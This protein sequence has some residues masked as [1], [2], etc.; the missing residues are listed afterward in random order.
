[1]SSIYI[2][3]PY[4]KQKCSYCSFYY[5]ISQKDKKEMINSLKKEIELRKQYLNNNTIETIYFGGGTPSILTESEISLLINTITE[6]YTVINN[7]EISLECNPDDLTKKKVQNLKKSGINRLSIGI[8]SFNDED[9][10]FMNR[11]HNS[12]QAIESVQ[13]AK[14]IGFNN[15]SIDLMYSLPQ[16]SLEKWKKNLDIAFSLE[17]QHISAYSLTIEEKTKL[18]SLLKKGE[19]SE[20]DDIASSEHFDLLMMEA[21]KNKFIQYEISNFGLNGF[22]S[23]HN[24][25]YWQ[26]GHYLGIGPSAHSYN[27]ET[28]SWNVNSNTK[29]IQDIS[30][31]KIECE[32]EILSNFQKYNDYIMTSLRTISGVNLNYIKQEY[33]ENYLIY[34]NNELHKWIKS[35]HVFIEKEIVYL[36]KKG[37]YISD[38]ICSDLFKVD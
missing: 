29:Y 28:R 20:L 16:Q 24:S 33:G 13:L 6:N 27:G 22:F 34:F 8:Q 37:K 1:M 4:C 21:E 19:F 15:I 32:E 14:E 12:S 7:A 2:H 23:K 10:K 25:K 35:E 30:E 31:N 17:I 3:I 9:L 26:A 38:N 11:S 5:R 18:K 36:S